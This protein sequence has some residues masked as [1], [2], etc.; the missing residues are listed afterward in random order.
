MA[1]LG[2]INDVLPGN[3]QIEGPFNTLVG[4]QMEPLGDGVKLGNMYIV[5]TF[6]CAFQFNSEVTCTWFLWWRLWSKLSL[7]F[8]TAER[9]RP[10]Q[11]QIFDEVTWLCS[12]DWS[13]QPYILSSVNDWKKVQRRLLPG[14]PLTRE[15]VRAA[16][17]GEG[18][19]EARPGLCLERFVQG[20]RKKIMDT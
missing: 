1:W 5:V 15:E 20:K 8:V 10:D 17:R 18:L 14:L 4:M 19:Y 12:V 9:W 13:E 16:G 6:V 7:S 3:G 11:K 2:H